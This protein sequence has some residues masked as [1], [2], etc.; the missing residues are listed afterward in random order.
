MIRSISGGRRYMYSNVWD[1]NPLADHLFELS[2]DD[3]FLRRTAMEGSRCP[4]GGGTGPGGSANRLGQRPPVRR[5][6]EDGPVRRG[7][8]CKRESAVWWTRWYDPGESGGNWTTNDAAKPTVFR[9][10]KPDL[11]WLRY[12]HLSMKWKTLGVTREDDLPET[13]AAELA[14]QQ[15]AYIDNFL[16]YNA[17]RELDPATGH[18]VTHD[19]I[20][21]R[22][23]LGRRSHPGMQGDLRAPA[24]RLR[25]NSR[26]A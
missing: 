1:S 24:R 17:G 9:H 10:E 8:G 21:L 26:R 12:R 13:T 11:H 19:R 2:R 3:G 20:R 14:N 23:A 5:L 25:W 16:G 15:P 4:Q 6:C 18:I 7:E 22:Q